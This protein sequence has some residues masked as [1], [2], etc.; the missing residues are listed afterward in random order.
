MRTLKIALTLAAALATLFLMSTSTA[1]AFELPDLHVLSG[2]FYPASGAGEVT[3][4]AALETEIGEKLTATVTS[5][6]MELT[7][8][9][10]LGRLIETWKGVAEPKSKTSCNTAG[11]AAGTVKV[12]G[13]YHITD[14]IETPLTAVVLLLLPD[15]V[16][17]CNSGKLKIKIKGPLLLK[18]EKVTAGVDS[19][20][21]G[22]VA[23]CSGKGKQELR[24]YLNE[25]GTRTK[26]APSANFGL[27]FESACES[28]AKE[29]VVKMS[30][31]T[32][33]LF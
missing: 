8:L 4:E 2:D 22:L 29:L 33:G 16:V 23:K 32:D 28:I 26:G 1:L 9:T 10:S 14:L 12:Q 7:V 19:T 24:E 25:E 27:G 30:K 18:L 21:F 31:M 20:E 13:E 3:A 11:D 5:V 15:P 6:T 17:E